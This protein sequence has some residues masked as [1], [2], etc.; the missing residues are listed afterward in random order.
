MPKKLLLYK[1][2]PI[3]LVIESAFGFSNIGFNKRISN[4]NLKKL[5]MKLKRIVKVL[6][7][8]QY[9]PKIRIYSH[10]LID[11]DLV[12]KN[13]CPKTKK[14]NFI[15]GKTCFIKK[16]YL[17]L[18]KDEKAEIKTVEI[19]VLKKYVFFS[20]MKFFLFISNFKKFKLYCVNE[21]K[22]KKSNVLSKPIAKIETIKSPILKEFAYI[23]LTINYSINK[24]T[25][26]IP[27]TNFMGYIKINLTNESEV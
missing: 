23:W 24:S 18:V 10:L 12:K 4:N 20:C 26:R 16:D 2:Y 9:I 25:F 15:E 17:N 21:I 27:D 5:P 19:S 22:R 11:R 7:K 14:V 3:G 13:T 8:L 6:K 1:T